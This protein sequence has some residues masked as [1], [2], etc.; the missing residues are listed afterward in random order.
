MKAFTSQYDDMYF[1]AKAI[2][3]GNYNTESIQDQVS[4]L[5]VGDVTKIHFDQ[6]EMGSNDFVLDK[7][8]VMEAEE[9]EEAKLFKK[10]ELVKTD[11]NNK[12][13]AGQKIKVTTSRQRSVRGGFGTSSVY[14]DKSVSTYTIDKVDRET[15]DI[16]SKSGYTQTL[17]PNK[18]VSIEIVEGC[19]Y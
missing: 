4:K 5:K 6:R 10:A 9:L 16:V 8:T 15:L 12:F 18:V 2:L 7:L 13:K 1:A 11:L 17:N 14:S 3:E 19:N